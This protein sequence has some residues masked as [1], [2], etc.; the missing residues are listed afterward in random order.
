MVYAIRTNLHEEETKIIEDL[1]ARRKIIDEKCKTR[2]SSNSL[3]E[4]GGSFFALR[5]DFKIQIH[6]H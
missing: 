6:F 5:I 3:I 2:P 1:L 4:I